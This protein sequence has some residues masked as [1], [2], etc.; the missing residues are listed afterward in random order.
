MLS[1][2]RGEWSEI[3]V[4]LKLISDQQVFLGDENLEKISDSTYKIISILRL[5]S[6]KQTIF[7]LDTTITIKTSNVLVGVFTL[8][9]FKYWSERLLKQLQKHKKGKFTFPE[10]EEFINALNVFKLKAKSSDKRD[11]TLEVYDSKTKLTPALGFSIKSQLGSPST[12]VNTSSHTNFT[13]SIKGPDFTKSEIDDINDIEEF[14]EKVKRI[15]EL[16]GKLELAKVDSTMFYNNL[17]MVD[18]LFPEIASEI[19]KNHY[20]GNARKLKDIADCIHESNPLNYNLGLKHKFYHSK[21]KRFLSDYAL[22]MRAATPWDGIHEA[23]GGYLIVK[24]NGDI[25][26]Y[27]FYYKNLFEEYLL[28]NTKTDTGDLKRVNALDEKP[29]GAIY[30]DAGFPFI[31]LNLQVRFLV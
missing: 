13:Y 30:L 15:V 9:E 27:H 3:Y 31:K 2:N 22:G 29:T 7:S 8:Q 4:L 28:N 16:G 24:K 18:S 20:S 10:L 17:V 25:I 14:A 26:C 1:G 6:N 12:L 19:V 5:D 21:I 23:N 11:I